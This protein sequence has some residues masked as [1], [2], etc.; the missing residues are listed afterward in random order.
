MKTKLTETGQI[1][2][3]LQ[4]KAFLREKEKCT[5]IYVKPTKECSYFEVGE[6]IGTLDVD[7]LARGGMSFI[8][9]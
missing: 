6:K 2:L 1:Q 4:K 9:T 3:I 5:D 8:N 7:W